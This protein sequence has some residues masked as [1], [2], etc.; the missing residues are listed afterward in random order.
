MKKFVVQFK[1]TSGWDKTA[2]IEA[3]IAGV[4]ETGDLVFQNNDYEVIAGY[5]KNSWTSFNAV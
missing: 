5:S 2:E 4:T 1:D 3:C